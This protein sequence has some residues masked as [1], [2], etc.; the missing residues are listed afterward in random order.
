MHTLNGRRE[1]GVQTSVG[2]A[3]AV[4]EK[5]EQMVM[6]PSWHFPRYPSQG[7]QVAPQ[8]LSFV[9]CG[10]AERLS[11]KELQLDA[12]G[13]GSHFALCS[14]FSLLSYPLS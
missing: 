4:Q 9:C 6:K 3:N 14:S 7:S 1:E 2:V 12:D 11:T 10:D 8:K 13:S 5:E